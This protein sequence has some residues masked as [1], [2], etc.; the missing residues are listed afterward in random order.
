[1]Q[2]MIMLL[3]FLNL[4]N[5]PLPECRGIVAFIHTKLLLFSLVI[6]LCSITMSVATSE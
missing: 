5:S 3:L 4:D 1:M 2:L 6:H